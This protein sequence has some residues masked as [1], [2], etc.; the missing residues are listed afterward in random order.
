MSVKTL[1]EYNELTRKGQFYCIDEYLYDLMEEA[2]STGDFST[3]FVIQ[4]ELLSDLK[5][6]GEFIDDIQAGN[7]SK[8]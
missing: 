5:I 8:D 2:K 7:N 1:E 3:L 6:C 4:R